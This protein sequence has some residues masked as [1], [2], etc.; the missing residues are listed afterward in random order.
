MTSYLLDSNVVILH[1]N[2]DAAT[3]AIVRKL[4][5]N[6]IAVSTITVMEVWQGVFRATD[7]LALAVAY[8]AFFNAILVIPFDSAIAKWCA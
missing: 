1:L 8:Q 6:G 5:G 3:Q 4:T 7:P 2:G